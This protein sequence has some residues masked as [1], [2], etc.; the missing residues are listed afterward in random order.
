MSNGLFRNN[1]FRGGS[2]VPRI[3]PDIAVYLISNDE[4]RCVYYSTIVFI[5]S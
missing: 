3:L 5:A 1:G 4:K 2:L